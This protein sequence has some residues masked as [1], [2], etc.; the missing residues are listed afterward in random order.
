LLLVIVAFLIFRGRPQ[1]TPPPNRPN[2]DGTLRTPPP[3]QPIVEDRLVFEGISPRV[4]DEAIEWIRV[5]NIFKPNSGVAGTVTGRIE[6]FHQARE[7]FLE[8]VG[9]RL[10]KSGRTTILAGRGDGFFVFE[11]TPAQ[12]KL[13]QVRPG[14]EGPVAFRDRDRRVT[15]PDIVLSDAHIDNADAHP[16][17]LLIGSVRYR[18]SAAAPRRVSLRLTYYLESSDDWRLASQLMELD[19]KEGKLSLAV[20]T[21]APIQQPDCV[22]VFIELVREDPG[23]TRVVSNTLATLVT[24]V[25]KKPK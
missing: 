24:V 16:G 5:N 2:E 10:L 25:G 12:A 3:T 1:P 6:G 8:F 14:A 11:L 17:G 23:R 21:N 19:G 9:G 18:A 22:V 7:T 15:P 20:K 4:R 13:V